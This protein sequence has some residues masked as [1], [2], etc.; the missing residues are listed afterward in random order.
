[1]WAQQLLLGEAVSIDRFI[2]SLSKGDNN[3]EASLLAIHVTNMLSL[4]ATKEAQVLRLAASPPSKTIVS[5]L[6][7]QSIYTLTAMYRAGRRNQYILPKV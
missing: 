5:Y 7:S 2:F 1:M 3:K 6:F 4:R